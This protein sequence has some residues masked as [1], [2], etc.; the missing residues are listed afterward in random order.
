[1]W[2]VKVLPPENDFLL[3]KIVK[4]CI[5]YTG[6]NKSWGY[7]RKN[8]F[9]QT[10]LIVTKIEHVTA[11]KKKLLSVNYHNVVAYHQTLKLPDYESTLTTIL[12]SNFHPSPVSNSPAIYINTIRP[13]V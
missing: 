13:V 2:T 7:L 5:P 1:M 10:K 12:M 9:E 11:G 8:F 6:S 4:F 3:L